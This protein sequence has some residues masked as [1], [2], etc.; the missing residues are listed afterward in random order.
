MRQSYTARIAE[1]E[2]EA[3][4]DIADRLV[5]NGSDEM[6]FV[7]YELVQFHRATATQLTEAEVEQLGAAMSSWAA[8]DTFAYS[9][10]GPAWKRGN[11]SD[12]T[13]IAWTRSD[14]R[15]WR[16]AAL[17]STVLLHRTPPA[18]HSVERT[19]AICARLIA[20]RD[21][22]VVK[23]LSWA[24]RTASKPDP[25]AV[26]QFVEEHEAALAARV[27]RELANKLRTGVKT[28]KGRGRGDA[29]GRG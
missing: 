26:A 29:I 19:L 7:A 18:P 28:P 20:D 4:L 5:R 12:K 6:R 13:V 3:V 11:I 23:A 22:M 14:N 16:R 24:L 25:A 27:K 1:L 8:V 15:W 21:D 9:I 17:S 2:R 10:S